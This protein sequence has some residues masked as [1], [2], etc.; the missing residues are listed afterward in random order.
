MLSSA[1]N[2]LW[3]VI[4]GDTDMALSLGGMGCGET[5]KAKTILATTDVT[6]TRFH[7]EL[8]AVVVCGHKYL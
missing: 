3:F 1:R 2:I 8:V 4:A 6:G 7:G 5:E